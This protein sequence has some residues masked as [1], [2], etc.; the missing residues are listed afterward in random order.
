[1]RTPPRIAPSILAADF[2][3]LARDIAALNDQIDLLHIDVMDGHFVPNISLGPPVITAIRKSTDHYLDCHLMISDPLTYLE[4][5]K[6]AGA[7]GVTVHIEAVPDPSG[8]RA[9]AVLLGMDFGLVIN[10][11][12]PVSAIE[13][14]LEM[15]SMVVVMSVH[16]G[17]G[18]QSFI[19]GALPKI[20]HL[21]EIIDS[22]ALAT[23]IEIDGGIDLRTAGPAREAGADVFVAGTSVFRADDPVA[24]VKEMRTILNRE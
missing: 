22:R 24:A 7:D 9:E 12:T 14:Y 10:P 15:A 23:D 8:V 6:A 19:E 1:M 18:G 17:Y 11:P 13:P 3:H 5:L 20:E 2:A 21:R 4:P 16:P